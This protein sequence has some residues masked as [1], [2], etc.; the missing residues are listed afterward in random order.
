MFEQVLNVKTD[1]FSLLCVDMGEVL[2]DGYVNISLPVRSHFSCLSS[3]TS[4]QNICLL[5]F[6][7]FLP[8]CR[9]LCVCVLVLGG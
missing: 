6:W 4:E 2:A 5:S 7:M 3:S 9:L 8:S 1:K